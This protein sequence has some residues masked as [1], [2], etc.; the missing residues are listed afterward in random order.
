[1]WLLFWCILCHSYYTQSAKSSLQALKCSTSHMIQPA[2][3]F[4][5]AREYV[6][7]L[8]V[9]VQ[10]WIFMFHR[11][12]S[13]L[14]ATSS[15]TTATATAFGFSFK[16]AYFSRDYL[17]LGQIPLSLL[18]N[19]LCGLLVLNFLHGRFP[20]NSVKALKEFIICLNCFETVGWE[21]EMASSL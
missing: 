8:M 9:M 5:C 17:R 10:T 4:D 11:F 1:M 14:W 19:N 18:R 2:A 7:L 3:F 16:P 13:L 21:T 15:F 20:T 6:L 12:C